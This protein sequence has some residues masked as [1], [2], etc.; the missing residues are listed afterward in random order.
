MSWVAEL[1]PAFPLDDKSDPWFVDFVIDDD[2]KWA[3][4]SFTSG[5]SIEDWEGLIGTCPDGPPCFV[6]FMLSLNGWP[7]FSKRFSKL[8][9]DHFPGSVQFLPITVQT[10]TFVN[11]DFA[12]G[13]ILNLVDA[14][15]RSH[16]KVDNDDWTPRL[17][18]TYRVQYP[19]HLKLPNALRFPV[20]RV[21]ESPIEI[22]IRNDFCEMIEEHKITGVRFDRNV[23]LH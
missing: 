8:I 1:L 6:D 17:N 5:E 20:F 10:K 4:E 22:F 11:D 15:D 16:T 19:I 13:V 18:G 9:T 23:P 21:P 14:V 3:G 7:L 12:I 2:S